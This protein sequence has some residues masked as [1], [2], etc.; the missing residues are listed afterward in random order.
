MTEKQQFGVRPGYSSFKH[1]ISGNNVYFLYNDM[2]QK[3]GMIRIAELTTLTLAKVGRTGNVSTVSVMDYEADTLAD[4]MVMYTSGVATT[5]KN[6][7]VPLKN[8][9]GRLKSMMEVSPT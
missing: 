2:P 4:I 8:L 9:K 7:L 3:M 6:F 5:G 1:M